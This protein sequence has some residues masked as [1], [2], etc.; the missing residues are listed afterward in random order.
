M[1]TTI[2]SLLFWMAFFSV[3][4]LPAAQ[5]VVPAPDGGYPG[6]NTAEGQNALLSL[7]IGTFNTAVGILSLRSDT[8][9]SFNTAIGAAT[10]L[11]NTG[12]ENTAI[13][14]GALLSNTTGNQNTANGAF[15]L[16]SNIEGGFNTATG[17]GALFS[18]TVGNSN[19]ADGYHAL[20]GNTTGDAN[21]ANGTSAL[22]HNTEG[23]YNTAIG[24]G[25]LFNNTGGS[26]NTAVGFSALS[27]SN[28]GHNTAVGQSALEDNTIGFSNTAIGFFALSNNTIGIRNT[29]VGESALNSAINFADNTAVGYD[30]LTSCTSG[31]NT[32]LGTR[33]GVNVTTAAHVI[34]IG[35]DVGGANVSNSCYVGNIFGQSSPNGLQVVVNSGN[36]LGTIPSS[37]RFKEKITPMA[38]ASKTLFLLKPVSFRYKKEVDPTGTPQLG[39]V[40]EEVDKLNPD[41]VVRDKE[42]KPYSVRY[43]QV[44]AMLL[45]EFLKEHRKVEKLE[46]TVADLAAQ[47]QKVSAQ[48]QMSNSTA[49]V[50]LSNH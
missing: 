7:T 21:T 39:L 13:G 41:L 30:A 6:G 17:N 16:Y 37:E 8:T 45:N 9:A 12:E 46:A 35:S 14:A 4:L 29:A 42:G 20:A 47:L 49:K 2:R 33:A 40:A 44:N 10:L 23:I 18:N 22:A 5:A 32:A 27:N 24:V 36:K 28:A 25:A 15:A 3:G 43:D 1:K 26:G 11:A 19:T 31:G 38:D 50:A 34:C 48:V